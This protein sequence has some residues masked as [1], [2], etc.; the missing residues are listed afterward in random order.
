MVQMKRQYVRSVN[1]SDEWQEEGGEGKGG[2][3]WG[4][5][6]EGGAEAFVC[7]GDLGLDGFQGDAELFGYLFVRHAV[8]LR[9][10]EDFSASVG[11]FVERAPQAGVA[12]RRINLFFRYFFS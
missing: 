8:A 11:Q 10:Q 2:C 7:F 5:D 3:G 6:A 1:M 4:G 9:H 12:L